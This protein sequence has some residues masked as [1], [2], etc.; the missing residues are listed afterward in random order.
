MFLTSK[1]QRE[2][3]K[4]IDDIFNQIGKTCPN[5]SIEKVIKE[6]GIKIVEDDNFEERF[7]E[8]YATNIRGFID[9]ENKT[10]Y[11]NQN[12]SKINRTFDLAHALGHYLLH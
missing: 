7:G 10:I 6:L 9:F 4:K 3:N 8:D 12:V 2:I 11:I 5:I 1:R